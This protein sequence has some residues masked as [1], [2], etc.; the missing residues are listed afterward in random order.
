MQH[1]ISISTGRSASCRTGMRADAEILP[2]PELL[3][4]MYDTWLQ[5]RNLLE[6]Y[7]PSWYSDTLRERVEAL[8]GQMNK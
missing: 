1:D 3:Q 2:A 5:M 6:Q 4:E 8:K 7:A